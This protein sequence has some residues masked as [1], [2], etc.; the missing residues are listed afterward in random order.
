M[1]WIDGKLRRE[2]KKNIVL[3]QY[4]WLLKPAGLKFAVK[5]K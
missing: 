5:W 3:V 4:P 1:T 2:I